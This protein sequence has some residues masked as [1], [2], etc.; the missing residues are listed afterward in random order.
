MTS[1]KIRYLFVD[2]ATVMYLYDYL[3]F[4]STIFCV[5]IAW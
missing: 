4:Y 3:P 1:T 2:T 5:V